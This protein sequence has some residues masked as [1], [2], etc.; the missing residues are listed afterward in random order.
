MTPL[1]NKALKFPVSRGAAASVLCE[2]SHTGNQKLS[3]NQY[4]NLNQQNSILWA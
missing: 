4:I 3:L 2:K 1:N